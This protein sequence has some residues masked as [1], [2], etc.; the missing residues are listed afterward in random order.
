MSGAVFV[1]CCEK[2]TAALL[3]V[4][5][6]TP[7][8]V[9]ST[10]LAGKSVLSL[11]L[12]TPARIHLGPEPTLEWLVLTRAHVA[13]PVDRRWSILGGGE[14]GTAFYGP[15]AGSPAADLVWRL[16]IGISWH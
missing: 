11:A 16:N 5:L 14:V 2:G 3:G 15:G 12:S 10:E 6:G 1:C 4:D 9:A 13:V 7:A 8:L